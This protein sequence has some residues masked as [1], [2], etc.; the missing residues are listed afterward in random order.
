MSRLANANKRKK[1]IRAF[2][3]GGFTLAE[4][5]EHTLVLDEQGDCLTSIPRHT[6]LSPTTLERI[7]KRCGL[8]V[9]QY[10][11]LYHKRGR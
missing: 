8:T 2:K 9:D 6:N 7:I 11:K 10:L 1:A 4:G 3:R 5:G